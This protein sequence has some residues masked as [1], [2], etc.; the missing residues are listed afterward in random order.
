MEKVSYDERL[1]L[2][3]EVSDT[4]RSLLEDAALRI[5]AIVSL[6]TEPN[7]D[8][9]LRTKRIKELKSSDKP[10]DRAK[11][12][13]MLDE[14]LTYMESIAH[15]CELQLDAWVESYRTQIQQILGGTTKHTDGVFEAFKHRRKA[16]VR[17]RQ[18]AYS[19]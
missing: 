11:L 12:L 15:G 6:D 3:A 19:Q 5:N 16:L 7:E 18:K 13:M 2:P 1:A 14:A 10:N 8:D 9:D 4:F 17:K